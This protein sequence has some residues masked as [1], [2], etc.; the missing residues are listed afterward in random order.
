MAR[1]GSLR[2]APLLAVIFV[3]TQRGKP[4]IVP[5]LDLKSLTESADAVVVGR[6]DQVVPQGTCTAHTTYGDFAAHQMRATLRVERLLK[7]SAFGPFADFTFCLPE[8]MIGY[9]PVG[10]D[11]FG[12]F[13]LHGSGHG[14][15]IL[16][17][18]HPYVVAVPGAVVTGGNA[19]EEVVGELAAVL[20]S[21]DASR[22]YKKLAV[23]SLGRTPGPEARSALL[24]GAIEKDDEVRFRSMAAL[25]R[26]NDITFLPA[27]ATVLLHPPPGVDAAL[28]DM[29]LAI[30]VGVLSPKAVPTLV[31]L[32]SAPGVETRRSAAL[33]LRFI[34]SAE[35][36]LPLA[37]A[38]FDSDRRVRY[39]AISGLARFTGQ[40]DWN[41]EMGDYMRKSEEPYLSH[42]REWAQSHQNK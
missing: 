39:E 2:I 6:V 29:A 19:F 17:P 4:T 12:V 9:W 33:S 26:R 5:R 31:K 22:D 3:A 28:D 16:D 24:K 7:G 37:Q 42:W 1:V 30:G 8:E 27:A 15:T 14:Y 41:P 23:L 34:G 38:L 36:I 35:A 18:Y 11:V 25:F 10:R 20:E 13:F 32:L 21:P 40:N